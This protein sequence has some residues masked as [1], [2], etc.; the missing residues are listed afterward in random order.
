MSKYS[1]SILFI[2]LLTQGCGSAKQISTQ[3]QTDYNSSKELPWKYKALLIAGDQ[4]ITAFDN[5]RITFKKYLLRKGIKAKNIR[6]LSRKKYYGNKKIALTTKKNIEA[7][8]K[9]LNVDGNTAC[10]VFMSSHGSTSGFLI[11]NESTVKPGELNRWLLKY[12]GSQPTILIVSACYSGLF[13]MK[14][15]KH[16]NRIILTAARHDKTSFGCGVENEYTYYDGCLIRNLNSS[17]NW[18]EVAEK[19]IRC[20]DKKEFDEKSH[21]QVFIGS[22]VEKLSLP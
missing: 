11:E 22:D 8:L 9:S 1:T 20:V 17:S 3:D 18:N 16:P 13:A 2:I 21:P 6:E 4:S 14:V 7:S 15:M 10:L 5:A 12:C 19:N